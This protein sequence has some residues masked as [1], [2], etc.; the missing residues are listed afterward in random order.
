MPL[1]ASL[2]MGG[3]ARSAA[4]PGGVLLAALAAAAL[5]APAAGGSGA[6]RVTSLRLS[7]EGPAQVRAYWTRSRMRAAP[8]VEA[9]LAEPIAT[10]PP[11]S[12]PAGSPTSVAPAAPG[13]AARASIRSG[14]A[15]AAASAFSPGSETSF[16]NRVHGRVF[17]TYQGEGDFT[18]SGTVVN[19]PGRSL[20][21]TAGHCVHTGSVWATNWTFVP[22]YRNGDAPFG[23]W[24]ASA[25]RAAPPW[26]ATEN[27]SF[28]LGMATVARNARGRAVQDVV[29]ARGIGFNQPREQT[30]ESFGY[31]AVGQFDGETLKACRS[32]Y[33]G[34]DEDTDQPRTMSIRCDMNEGSSG[35]GW[36]AGGRLL[37][38]NS[39]YRGIIIIRL[40]DRL[41]G[42]YLG[43]VAERLYRAARGRAVRCGGRRVTQLGT[44]AAQT[45]SGG[46]GPDTIRLGPGDDTGRGRGGADRICGGSGADNLRGGPGRDF[47]FGGP[48]RDRASG[49]EVR[50][51]I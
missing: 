24:P 28:D 30:Y 22:G 39:Y 5:L 9:L 3:R 49:C 42:P 2:R 13:D 14:S 32:G 45:L 44:A 50:R 48:G 40:E 17:A 1:L 37:S 36:V 19:S 23:R 18:C 25:L 33:T 10:S 15:G 46:R 12:E 51:G 11:L 47:C 16:P 41:F 29:G 34:A 31:P 38:V 35:G 26:V 7:D 43:D 4:L 27:I 21:V 20:V 8:P 6:E